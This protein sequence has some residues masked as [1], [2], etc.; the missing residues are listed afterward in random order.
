MFSDTKLLILDFFFFLGENSKSRYRTT[1][2]AKVQHALKPM[3]SIL[4]ENEINSDKEP[5]DE[6]PVVKLFEAPEEP[7]VD[8]SGKCKGEGAFSDVEDRMAELFN[9]SSK[10]DE[11]HSSLEALKHDQTTLELKDVLETCGIA[12]ESETV[13][14]LSE[15]LLPDNNVS[16]NPGVIYVDEAGEVI[17]ESQLEFLSSGTEGYTFIEMTD[18]NAPPNEESGFYFVQKEGDNKLVES[19]YQEESRIVQDVGPIEEGKQHIKEEVMFQ[20]SNFQCEICGLGFVSESDCTK[21]V[22]MHQRM[23]SAP[24]T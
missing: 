1:Y 19:G 14:V 17:P 10:V 23:E 7:D 22:E 13:G 11:V 3:P 2:K 16:G 5:I 4:L 24:T 9:D 15:E 21:H 8:L 6:L 20:S 12:P 18:E